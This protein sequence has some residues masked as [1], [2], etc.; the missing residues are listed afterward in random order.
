MCVVHFHFA[1]DPVSDLDVKS[2][3][4]SLRSKLCVTGQACLDNL[5]DQV[6]GAFVQNA[7]KF[8]TDGK[9]CMEKS[10][11]IENTLRSTEMRDDGSAVHL[12]DA[13]VCVSCFAELCKSIWLFIP[14]FNSINLPAW[15]DGLSC[16]FT[17]N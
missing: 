2:E 16:K 9:V 7:R 5:S 14:P 11:W 8:S 3:I 15:L 1:P 6:V 12:S 13:V 4:A 10:I 17:I